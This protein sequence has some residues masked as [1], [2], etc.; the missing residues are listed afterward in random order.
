MA[1]T[2]PK[3]RTAFLVIHGIGEQ[4]P[5]DTLDDFA[6]GLTDY[7]ASEGIPFKLAHR[8][9]RRAGADGSGWVESFVRIAAADGQS[10]IDVH[11]YYWAYLTE[12]QISPSEVWEWIGQTLEGAI[13][14]D[15]KNQQLLDHYKRHSSWSRLKS[16]IRSLRRYGFWIRLALAVLQMCPSWRW[17]RALQGWMQRRAAWFISGYIGDIAVYTTT[18]QKS[19]HYRIRQKILAESQTM[20][21]V[22]L[23]DD[24]CD[25]GVIAGHSLGSVIAYDTLNRLNVRANLSGAGELPLNKLAGLITFGSPL[26]LVAF[27]FREHSRPEQAIRRQIID[28][29]HSFKSRPLEFEKDSYRLENPLH[30][31]LDSVAWVNYYNDKDPISGELDFYRILEQDNVNVDLPERWGIAHGGYWH[32]KPFYADIARRF[33]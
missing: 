4:N 12:K 32:H 28:Q 9:V 17:V 6:R 3:N 30:P 20:L 14:Y 29:L 13:R 2:F 33:L 22:L 21:E 26:D 5:F 7:L 23:K 19:S 27:F 11:E 24:A 15:K 31:L 25:R 16:I 1:G 10:W 18:D 8:L